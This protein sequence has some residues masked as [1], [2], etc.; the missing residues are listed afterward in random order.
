M[1]TTPMVRL[2]LV[3]MLLVT[4]GCGSW[5]S[6]R[7]GRSGLLIEPADAARIGYAV[8]WSTDLGISRKSEL[9]SVT[10]LG[11]IL[12]TVETPSNLVSA[13]SVRDGK[14]LWRRIVGASTESV[15]PPVRNGERVYLNNDT[16]IFTLGASHGDL[17]VSS[18][19][20]RVVQTGPALLG[21][22]AIFGGSDG[23]VFAHDVD[24][25]YE[26]W[27][28][29]LSG[30]IVAPPVAS[31]QS[32]FV[33]DSKGIYAMLRAADGE[34]LFRGRTFGPVTATPAS[35]RGGV[36]LASHDQ[37]LYALDRRTGRDR[38]VY[39]TAKPLTDEPTAIGQSVYLPLLGS[40]LVALSSND[41]Q[42]LW[43]SDLAATPITA[44]GGELLLHYN[45]GLR[46]VHEKT[47]RVLNDA[48]TMRLK[49]ALP[50]P[51]DSVLIVSP[52]GRIHRLNPKR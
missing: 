22:Y 26:K 18:S 11:D 6:R 44:G 25:G 14:V 28:Y 40:G 34:L 50:G 9:A 36:Y 10:L 30:G 31:Q 1:K 8:S 51:D 24:A 39:R 23:T 49:A 32:V 27:S 46:L 7:S 41:G 35:T 15:Y 43:R 33:A 2:L 37:S 4:A 52:G 3:L 16:T 19:L 17:I 21:H 20:A 48:E 13:V 47:G 12:L 42:E 38:W 5:S 45:G 29:Q